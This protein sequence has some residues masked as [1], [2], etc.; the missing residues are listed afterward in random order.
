VEARPRDGGGAV[1]S[2][3]LPLAEADSDD[4]PSEAGDPGDGARDPARG[5]VGHAPATP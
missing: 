1:F 2:V 5:P 4:L 3:A